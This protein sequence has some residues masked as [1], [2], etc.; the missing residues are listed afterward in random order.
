MDDVICQL[1]LVVSNMEKRID[2]LSWK[3]KKF[4]SVCFSE[5]ES[6]HTCKIMSL[7]NKV[8]RTCQTYD[9]I[10][11]LVGQHRNEQNEFTDSLQVQVNLVK[12]KMETL[13][14]LTTKGRSIEL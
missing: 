2:T 10:L 13:M 8:A 12:S 11:L 1:E 5:K 3:I 7:M 9:E 6:T 4:E 14:A